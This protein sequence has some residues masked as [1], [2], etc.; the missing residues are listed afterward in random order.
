MNNLEIITLKKEN[1]RDFALARNELLDKAGFGWVM[2]IDSDEKMG[3]GL[4]EEISKAVN[5]PENRYSGF[6]VKRKIYLLGKYVGTDKVIRLAK[7]GSGK[8]YRAV[9]EVWNVKGR[10]GT[11]KNYL[12][13]NTY[14]SV[15]SAISKINNYSS[16]HALEN[17][18]E[19]KKATLFKII[20]Y[21]KIKFLENL[22][23]G[24]GFTFSMLQSFHSFLGWAKEWELQRKKEI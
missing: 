23:S 17:K 6:Y 3:P 15:F 16:L 24:R 14:D 9:H 8:W 1:I 4:R 12:I 22:L 18:K 10:T 20:V 13:H 2:F 5:N 19:G 7:K 21:P 11:L